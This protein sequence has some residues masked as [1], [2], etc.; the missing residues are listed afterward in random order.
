VAPPAS[1]PT[2]P[3]GATSLMRAPSTTT[4]APSMG[5]RP[6]PSISSAWVKSVMPAMKAS[7]VGD[8]TSGF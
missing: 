6:V 4:V 2:R 8:A 1:G 7:W 5:S 3:E